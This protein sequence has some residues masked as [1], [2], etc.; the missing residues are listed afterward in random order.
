[1]PTTELKTTL[2]WRATEPLYKQ[3][4]RNIL[5]C[6]AQGEW[7]PGAQL[8]TEHELAERFGVA[9][10]TVRAGIGQLGAA[11]IL[12]RRQGKGT[13]VAR[14]DR[15]RQTNLYSKVF[16]DDN[17]K[18]MTTNH[19][20]TTFRKQL[21]DDRA[22]ELLHLD[23]RQKQFVYYWEAVLKENERAIGFRR[24]TMPAHLFPG[25]TARALRGKK[26]NMY[27]FYEDLCG[28]NVIRF[29][30]RVRATKADA[31]LAK[32]LG[33]NQETPLLQIDRISFTYNDVPVELRTRIFDGLRYHYHTAQLGI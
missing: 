25:L 7:K 12:V 6:L 31:Q 33:V 26:E 22:M 32:V 23:Q 5:Q 28:V 4:A 19:T 15:D 21:A 8:P 27:A 24:V 13:F 10:Y 18:L 11:G 17:R 30:D 29:E 3:I 2:H 9:I 20:V 14:H 1:M 16:H